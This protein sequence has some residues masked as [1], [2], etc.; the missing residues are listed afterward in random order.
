MTVKRPMLWLSASFVVGM[1]ILAIF[2]ATVSFTAIFCAIVTVVFLWVKCNDIFSRVIYTVSVL[3]FCLGIVLYGIADDVSTRSL[4]NYCSE[5][6]YLTGEVTED[7]VFKDTYIRFNMKVN[8][9]QWNEYNDESINDKISVTYFTNSSMI[10]VPSIKYGDIVTVKGTVS[11]PSN[12]KNTGGFDYAKYLK[13]KGIYFQTVAENNELHVVGR[14]IHPFFDAIYSFRRRCSSIFDERFPSDK[15]GVLKAYILGDSSGIQSDISEMFS[16]SGLTH[17]LAVSGMHLVVFLSFFA[18]IY[19][20]MG[21]SIHKRIII[22][23]CAVIIY[24]IFTGASIATIRAGIV[25][26]IAL[27]AQFFFRYSDPLTALAEAAAVLCAVNPIVILSASHMLSFSST[28]GILLFSQKISKS[29]SLLYNNIENKPKVKR[30]IRTI[31]NLTAMGISAQVFIF[32]VLIYL[33]NEFSVMSVVATVLINPLLTPLLVGGLL[34]CI[35]SLISKAIAYPVA[36]F[37]YVHAKIMIKIAEFFG[38][39]SFSKISFGSITPFFIIMYIVIFAAVY[40]TFFHRKK[41]IS[42][43]SLYSIAALLFVFTLY[44]NSYNNIAEVCFI[45]VGQGDCSLIKAPGNCDI[46]IDA[47][48]K[49]NNTSVGKNVVKPY[50]LNNGVTDI[51]YVI[52]SHGHEDHINGIISLIDEI[53]IKQILVPAGFGTTNESIDLINKANENNIP[54]TTVKHGD[55]LYIS[56]KIQLTVIMPDDKILNLL[57]DNDENDRSLLL[58]LE[59]GNTSF[60]YTGDLSKIGEMYA[61]ATYTDMLSADVLKISHHGSYESSCNKFLDSVDPDYAFISVG[62]NNYGHPSDDV[63][64]RLNLRNIQYYR[65]DTHNDVIFYFDENKIRGIKFNENHATG[66]QHELR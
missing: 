48:G 8:S 33:F 3:L 51:E 46:L 32:P 55:V 27:S 64:C 65:A 1:Y 40:F 31:C 63:L 44:N 9:L 29:F 37:I 21:I 58:R 18:A 35:L 49:K 30:T 52:A 26:L 24:V 38:N 41:A 47:G 53:E 34:F 57:D 66:G 4:Y 23:G 42:L 50:L 60:L 28:L 16:A 54:I 20:I 6:V 61:S 19:R 10:D 12:A 45:N 7:A 17:V 56:D 25:C 15:S 59:Y 39:F 14:N 13:S 2:G 62:V 36:G 11:L 22:S 5:Q 43:I